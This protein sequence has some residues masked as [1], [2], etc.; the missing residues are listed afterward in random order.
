MVV[1]G[2]SAVRM[3]IRLNPNTTAMRRNQPAS[4][5]PDPGTATPVPIAVRPQIAWPWRYSYRTNHP[6]RR[7][8]TANADADVDA[9]PSKRGRSDEGSS[10]GQRGGGK[11]SFESHDPLLAARRSTPF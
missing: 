8:W 9:H 6:R 11:Y 7:R 1:V 5:H 4:I 2:A 3:I 10:N